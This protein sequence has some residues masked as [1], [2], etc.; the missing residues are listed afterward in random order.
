M[1]ATRKK[2]DKGLGVVGQMAGRDKRDR[3]AL[4]EVTLKRQL[5]PRVSEDDNAVK[6]YAQNMKVRSDGIVVDQSGD[7]WP[8]LVV[9][10]KG[11]TIWL[12]DGWH[13]YKAAKKK[14]ITHFQVKRH[15]GT[16]RD[17]LLYSFQVNDKHGLR[18]TRSDKRRVVEKAL[19]DKEWRKWSDRMIA[20]KCRV[21]QTFVSKVRREMVDQDIIPERDKVMSA[22]GT[23]R[24]VSGIRESNR[25]SASVESEHNAQTPDTLVEVNAQPTGVFK[26]AD[27]GE[28][29]VPLDAPVSSEPGTQAQEEEVHETTSPLPPVN[30]FRE[31]SDSAWRKAVQ[32]ALKGQCVITPLPSPAEL[33]S[34]VALFEQQKVPAREY[35][36]AEG[37]L[38]VLWS[39][40]PLPAETPVEAKSLSALI[41]SMEGLL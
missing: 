5:Q 12:V 7:E 21:S 9:F 3:V 15:R 8:S 1:G 6:E 40:K 28:Q 29:L 24:D 39:I 27:Q 17:A 34:K 36:Q 25:K 11:D 23:A 30:A 26:R 31:P 33:G 2:S 32:A 38:W 41:K 16:L 10:E 22:D 20:Q 19:G 14:G 18:R 35:C 13:R 4:E 37:K